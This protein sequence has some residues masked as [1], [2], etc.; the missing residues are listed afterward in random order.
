MKLRHGF[1][2]AVIAV[3]TILSS[4]T[5]NPYR[6]GETSEHTYFGSF[7]TPPTKLDPTSAYYVHEGRIIDQIYE[8]PFTYHYLKRPYELIPLTAEEVPPPVYFDKAGRRL[9][10]ADPPP[11]SVGHVEYTIR[12]KRGIKYQN[13]PCFAKDSRGRLL[14]RNVK[15]GDI[16]TYE[17]P[18]DFDH[19]GTRELEA[20][21]Y[22]LQIRRLADP[23]LASPIL[24][25]MESYILGMDKLHETYKAMLEEERERRRESAGAGY[26][27]EKDEK[28]R[29]ILLDYMKPD[30]PGV[31]IIDDHTYKVV[32]KRKYP[33]ILY[34]MSMHFFGPVPQ[35]AVGFFTQPAMAEKQF[36]LNRCPVG[37]GPYYLKVFRP[38]QLMV[39][40]RNPNYHDDSYPTEG[41]T[42]DR[43]NGLLAD[44]GQRVP[45]V[46]RQVF[47]FEKESIP[48]WNKFL[49]GYLDASGIDSDV[50]DQA[51]QIRG[52]ESMLT[53]KM[54]RKGIR[55]I[56]DIDT[57]FYYLAFNMRDDVVGYE[58]EKGHFDE[59]KCKLR[60]AISIALDYNEYL[61]IFANGRGL[62]GQGPIP[63]GIFGYRPGKDGTN[64]F[65]DEWNPV[66][67][68][69]VRKPIDVA[70]RLMK[71][72]GYP[73]GRGADGRPLTLH[74]DHAAGVDPW[75]RS[76]FDWM[77]WKLDQI[78]VRLKDRGTEL[79]R[80]RQKRRQ[81]NWQIATSGWL[82][83]YP[84]PENFMFLFYGPNGKV[85]FGGPNAYNYKN[86][87]F[88]NLFVQ[89]ESMQN[90][91]QRQKI[92]EKMMYILRH[93]APAVWMFHPVSY[94]LCHEWYKNVKP[95]RMS[96][97]TM[98]YKRIDPRLRVQRQGHWNKPI[99]W[100]VLCVLAVLVMGTI[101][102]GITIYRR[103]RAKQ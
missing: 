47:Y 39:L 92:I 12:I 4:C 32:L 24:S 87:E 83:D 28:N 94:V 13:H 91:P 59:K 7:G 64:P 84:D 10:D 85:E 49:Q 98:K 97:N 2:V 74:Y 16:A 89:M 20:K 79:G 72:A 75:F 57:S 103:E 67:K 61:D 37:S 63:P 6:P 66:R 42:G 35:E 77:R 11:E 81:G 56:T 14:Y 38:N 78:G 80:F 46:A 73:G 33:Q 53:D 102:A 62:L 36:S 70:K 22:A 55:L 1:R 31:E 34:W 88:D 65:V 50:F 18:S 60:Q 100:P 44:A 40:E 76:R 29:P 23:R 82:A 101:P 21:D 45:F 68:R 17:Y 41:A 25:A 15:L 19:Q 54:K 96:Y 71:E 90:S 95:H 43:E 93:D 69:H 99:V 27:Q 9:R 52:G 86:P 5:N 58:D 26:N 30:F 51:I 8:P 48:D 3:V